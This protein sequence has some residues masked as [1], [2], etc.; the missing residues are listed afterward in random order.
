MQQFPRSKTLVSVF[1][2]WKKSNHICWLIWMFTGARV[3]SKKKVVFPLSLEHVVFDAA[4]LRQ[5]DN[6]ASENHSSVRHLK[7]VSVKSN[8][9]KWR[10]NC[11]FH[12]AYSHFTDDKALFLD[13]CHRQRWRF[14][15][16]KKE[17]ARQA[18][19]HFHSAL[20]STTGLIGLQPFVSKKENTEPLGGF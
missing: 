12:I 10:E 13:P 5:C 1:I 15:R 2:I 3:K 8:S 4:E 9:S 14:S 20:R 7:H 19:T 11:P 6:R 17:E 18:L 16:C